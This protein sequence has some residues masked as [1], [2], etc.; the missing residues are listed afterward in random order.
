[1]FDRT[2]PG[3]NPP[4]V[5]IRL[6]DGQTLRAAARERRQEADASWWMKVTVTLLVQNLTAGGRMTSEPEPVSFW[7]PLAGGVCSPIEGQDYSGVPTTRDPGLL[8]RQARAR[9]TGRG[10]G[11]RQEW[12]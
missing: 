8:R 10:R 11:P 6:P 1:M 7:A 2:D 3:S 4:Q 12:A 5:T 9:E